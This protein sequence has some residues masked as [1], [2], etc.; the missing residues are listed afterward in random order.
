M[1]YTQ[2]KNHFQSSP[3]ILSKEV[4]RFQSDKQNIRN[5]LNR[6]LQKGLI[7]KLKK[8]AYL[9][10]ENDR[11]INPDHSFIANQLYAPSYVSLEY[12][13]YIYGLIPEK[14][15]A[16]TSITTKKTVRFSNV[17]GEYIYQHVKPTAFGGFRRVK[18]SNGY[19]IFIAEPEKAVVDFLY[20]NFPKVENIHKDI[21]EKSY[22][23][24]N[25]ENLRPK[26]I[27]KAAKLF[28]NRALLRKARA[29]CEFLSEVKS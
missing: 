23:F 8:G 3:L 11:K 20:L 26:E 1:N 14:V 19:F 27:M 22:R 6:W 24:Q 16:I 13:L 4:I 18:D 7:H 9:F 12:A 17:S 28:N 15:T 29:F 21:F 5:Q 25:A 2:F 10:N